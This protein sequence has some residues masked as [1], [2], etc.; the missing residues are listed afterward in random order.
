[1]LGTASASQPSPSMRRCAACNQFLPRTCFRG[2]RSARGNLGT[3]CLLC[4]SRQP[5]SV[6]RWNSTPGITEAGCYTE[7]DEKFCPS[8]KLWLPY[9]EYG[10]RRRAESP[11]QVQT[12]CRA[13]CARKVREVRGR[14]TGMLREPVDSILEQQDGE[15]RYCGTWVDKRT[16]RFETLGTCTVVFCV[17]CWKAKRCMTEEAFEAWLDNI[18]ENWRR[19]E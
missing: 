7:P 17:A 11:W 5:G 4:E 9:S 18:K 3:T 6:Y 15:C 13:C 12:Y 2:S 10:V 8:C 1:M 19:K 16:M 14:R